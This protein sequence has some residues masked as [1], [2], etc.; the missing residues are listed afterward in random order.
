M[1]Q[2]K[3]GNQNT[4]KPM[5]IGRCYTQPSHYAPLTVLVVAFSTAAWYKM[6]HV[7]VVC[8]GIPHLYTI[9]VLLAR[10]IPRYSTRKRCMSC[11]YYMTCICSRYNARSD[12]VILGHHHSPY[13]MT[14]G[15][16]RDYKHQAESYIINYL[17]TSNVR[18]FPCR[19][20]LAVREFKLNIDFIFYPRISRYSKVIKF[21]SFCLNY[22]ETGY[23]TQ[24]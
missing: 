12:C 6:Q 7:L 24:N 13:K 2:K 18:F 9:R 10:E 1:S 3:T 8:H 11:I 19:I 22:L 14:T 20:D 17:L 5:Y 4:G 16:L 23:G 15:R 21:V